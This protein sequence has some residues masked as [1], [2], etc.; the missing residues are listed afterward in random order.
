MILEPL[1][2]DVRF[3]P[4]VS[5]AIGEILFV[6]LGSCWV[7]LRAGVRPIVLTPLFAQKA[8][9]IS[10]TVRQGGV[11]WNPSKVWQVRWS[12]AGFFK[13]LLLS[14]SPQAI[15]VGI[16]RYMVVIQDLS[17]GYAAEHAI[18]A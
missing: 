1:L 12:I 16:S 4:R 13:F 17:T 8:L 5:G 3:V 9:Q 6:L 10:L 11:P 15:L 7:L 18:C 2:H 14:P